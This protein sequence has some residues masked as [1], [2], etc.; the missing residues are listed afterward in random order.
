[1]NTIKEEGLGYKVLIVTTILIFFIKS[2]Q[3]NFRAS[4][5]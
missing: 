1:M 2:Y 5:F 4:M 3:F